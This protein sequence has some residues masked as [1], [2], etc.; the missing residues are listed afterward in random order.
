MAHLRVT[1]AL[2]QRAWVAGFIRCLAYLCAATSI[3]SER[4]A[5]RISAL[6]TTFIVRFGFKLKVVP[7]DG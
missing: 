6:S 1:L 7:W 2:E 3:A 4:A 5:E